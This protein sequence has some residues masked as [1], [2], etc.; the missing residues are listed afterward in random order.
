MKIFS[1]FLIALALAASAAQAQQPWMKLDEVIEIDVL[2]GWR[3]DNG[4]HV[5][6][7]QIRLAPGWVTYW[8]S[9]GAAGI[10]PQMDWRGSENAVSVSPVWPKPKV[11]NSFMGQ[12]IGYDSD[13]VL[14]LL[15]RPEANGAIRL[16][17]ALDIGVCRDICLPA[18]VDVTAELP[19]TGAPDASIQAALADQPA[20]INAPAVCR[21]RPTEDGMA[22]AG[23]IALPP[24]GYEEAVVFEVPDPSIWVTDAE[25]ARQGDRLVATTELMVGGNRPIA[26]DRS[27]VR[28]TIIGDRDAVEIIGC[29]G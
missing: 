20:Q 7:L 9:A 25:V 13:F 8:R 2:P 18:K 14:P 24:L 22:L 15:I 11:F 29:V 4:D 10:S 1:P 6:G 28:I 23:E 26:V 5:A 19:A 3:Q 17:G 16:Q 27:R 21:L 12:S